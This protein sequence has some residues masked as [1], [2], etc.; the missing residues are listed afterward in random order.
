[1]PEDCTCKLQYLNCKYWYI[2][3]SISEHKRNETN[4]YIKTGYWN[5]TQIGTEPE[6]H[7]LKHWEL[8]CMYMGLCNACACAYSHCA[9]AYCMC[10]L[11][12]QCAYCMCNV[13]LQ[14]YYKESSIATLHVLQGVE[15]CASRVLL[16]QQYSLKVWHLTNV[17]VHEWPRSHWC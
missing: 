2:S 16:V 5:I 12:V 11:H 4:W 15:Y 9:C 3:C 1:M 13:H 7:V 8:Q 10:L 14:R 17:P 6:P